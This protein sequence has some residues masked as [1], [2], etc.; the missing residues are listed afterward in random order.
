MGSITHLNER[1]RTVPQQLAADDQV[2]AAAEQIAAF[3][4]DADVETVLDQVARV[5]LLAISIPS[6]FG[7][8]DLPNDV[9]ARAVSIISGPYPRAGLAL[10]S[11]FAAL[12]FVRTSGTEEQRR[13]VYGRAALG[14]LFQLVAPEADERRPL[15]RNDGIGYGLFVRPGIELPV[16]HGWIAFSAV[17]ETGGEVLALVAHNQLHSLT[18]P[19]NASDP[20]GGATG[21]HVPGDNVLTA[22]AGAA[23]LA[24]SL[25]TL[26]DAAVLLGEL[27]GDS[28]R[29]GSARLPV[30]DPAEAGRSFM[31]LQVL[32]ALMLRVASALD[33]VQVGAEAGVGY[34]GVA[35]LAGTLEVLVARLRGDPPTREEELLARI[36]AELA[37]GNTAS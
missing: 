28:A 14:E 25:A 4:R 29:E 21:V 15:C 9:I 7:G 33:A 13:G 32:Q 19:E 12:E 10:S 34:G 23:R 1:L 36:G 20:E 2:V 16:Q 18:A 24:A 22:G 17:R 11:H 5:G 37:N 3:S 31:N 26:L 27:A 6:E 35:S 30:T 8:A